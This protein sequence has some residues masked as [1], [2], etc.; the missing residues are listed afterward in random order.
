MR[1]SLVSNRS[2]H[3][4]YSLQKKKKKKG[5]VSVPS[6]SL[7]LLPILGVPSLSREYVAAAFPLL[8]PGLRPVASSMVRRGDSGPLALGRLWSDDTLFSGVV[9]ELADESEVW[10]WWMRWWWRSLPDDPLRL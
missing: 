4:N 8:P 2:M 9:A 3:L 6:R 1:L 7:K 10:E 5:R